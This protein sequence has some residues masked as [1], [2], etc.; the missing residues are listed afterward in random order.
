L[1]LAIRST[2]VDEL[3]YGVAQAKVVDDEADLPKIFVEPG[4]LR[5]GVGKG[6]FRV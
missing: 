6:L 4:E 5:G 2:T 1:P 3:G